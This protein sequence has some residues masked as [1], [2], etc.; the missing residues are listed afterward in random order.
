MYTPQQEQKAI[1]LMADIE[2]DIQT[3]IYYLTVPYKSINDFI[4][5]PETLENVLNL[6]RTI[7]MCFIYL[8]TN[9]Q[10]NIGYSLENEDSDTI[11]HVLEKDTSEFIEFFSQDNIIKNYIFE[12]EY[13][14]KD[15]FKND[16][17]YQTLY[18]EFIER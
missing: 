14:I 4:D 12:N 9:S 16:N 7:D 5:D 10:G 2:N 13:K 6:K 17:K 11:D 1:K 8:V 15:Q 18:K 3:I